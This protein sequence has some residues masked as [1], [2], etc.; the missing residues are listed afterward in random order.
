MT[1]TERIPVILDVDTGTDDAIAILAAVGCP[2]I[3]LVA[4][5]SVRGNKPVANTTENSLR[6]LEAVGST[7]PVYRGCALPLC[8]DIADNRL[9][10]VGGPI[11]EVDGQKIH[12]H[13][14]YLDLPSA[15]RTA[16]TLPAPAFYVEYLRN[17]TKPVTIVI[18]GPLTNVAAAL[19]MDPGIV[20]NIE[21]IV[22]MGGG[23]D[24]ANHSPYAE[25]NIWADPEA[26]Q[27]VFQADTEVV[28]VPLDATEQT[29][30]TLADAA[31]FRNVGN[32]AA[33]F[34]ADLMDHRIH[35]GNALHPHDPP[36][37][38]AV[39]DALALLA[40]V[41]PSLLSGRRVHCDVGLSG[42][43]EGVTLISTSLRFHVED[44][45]KNVWFAFG[46]D[47]ARFKSMLIDCLGRV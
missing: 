26:A 20:A 35:V 18:V 8:K 17:C 31:D 34:A 38:T 19:M 3:D 22:V 47:K 7:I 46:A 6:V 21:K 36:G 13:P 4:V 14:E 43:A 25:F 27:R 5:C 23:H 30:F 42:F 10:E 9:P 1:K 44:S 2:A 37:A 16:E 15:T 29:A 32:F 28:V 11:A 39:H 45:E 12:V 40:V 41:D 24:Y 33:S